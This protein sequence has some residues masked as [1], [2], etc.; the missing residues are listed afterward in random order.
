M[1]NPFLREGE[2]FSQGRRNIFSG[3]KKHLL[4]GLFSGRN[5]VACE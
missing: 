4:R 3:K 1:E 2:T 5:G